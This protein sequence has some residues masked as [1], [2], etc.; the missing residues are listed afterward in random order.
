MFSKVVGQHK[1]VNELLAISKGLRER[2]KESMSILLTGPAGYG[3]TLLAKSFCINIGGPYSYQI[4][5]DSGDIDFDIL[6]SRSNIIDEAHLLKSPERIY[7]L[8]TQ[9]TFVFCTTSRRDLAEPLISRCAGISL[10]DYSTEELAK[11]VLNYAVELNFNITIETARLVAERSR[12][13]PRIAKMLLKRMKYQIESEYHPFTLKGIGDAYEDIGVFKGGYT[14]NDIRY[15]KY[16]ENHSPSS[17]STICRGIRIDSDI[18]RE[19][20]EPF[21]LNKGHIIITNKGREFIS[22][23]SEE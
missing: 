10:V 22:W 21:L 3:K 6:Y 12:G 16:L 1:A 4:P 7:D 5:D 13:V 20:V 18:I 15:M 17:F 14:E 8:I 9:R 11:I 2:P 23:E 19:D